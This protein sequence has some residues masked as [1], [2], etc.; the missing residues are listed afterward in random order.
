MS[1][2]LGFEGQH[3]VIVLEPVQISFALAAMLAAMHRVEW[4]AHAVE[5]LDPA[6]RVIRE[7]H[8]A[9]T[10]RHLRRVVDAHAAFIEPRGFHRCSMK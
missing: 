6:A 3:F 1:F 8:S 7:P 10:D 5:V 9:F 4:S 2:S